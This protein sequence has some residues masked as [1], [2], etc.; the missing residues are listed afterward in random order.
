MELADD[1]MLG[2]TGFS[3]SRPVELNSASAILARAGLARTAALRIAFSGL[4][5]LFGKMGHVILLRSQSLG[6]GLIASVPWYGIKQKI[7]TAG[8]GATRTIYS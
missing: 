2:G 6:E 4:N 3:R 5:L 8:I 1:K 7:R